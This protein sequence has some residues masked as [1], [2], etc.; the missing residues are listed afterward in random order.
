VCEG[1]ATTITIIT[2]TTT[3]TMITKGMIFMPTKTRAKEK[4]RDSQWWGKK[5]R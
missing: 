1:A 2:T 3:T 4:E 5:D